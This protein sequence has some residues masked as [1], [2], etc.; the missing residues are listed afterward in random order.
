M[1]KKGQKS[2]GEYYRALTKSDHSFCSFME[3]EMG[4]HARVGEVDASHVAEWLRK[5]FDG[6]PPHARYCRAYLRAAH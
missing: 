1:K 4:R 6:A 2:H 5:I 3:N